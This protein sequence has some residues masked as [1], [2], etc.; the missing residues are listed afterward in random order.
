MAA[1][2]RTGGVSPDIAGALVNGAR[3]SASRAARRSAGRHSG[4]SGCSGCRSRGAVVLVGS[5]GVVVAARRGFPVHTHAQEHLST[6]SIEAITSSSRVVT[7]SVPVVSRAI[8]DAHRV[9]RRRD[10]LGA[11]PP[12]ALRGAGGCRAGQICHARRRPPSRS[13]RSAIDG[14]VSC[15]LGARTRTAGRLVPARPSSCASV[16]LLCRGVAGSGRPGRSAR[17]RRGARVRR[18]RRAP[19]WVLGAVYASGPARA[20]RWSPQTRR[21]AEPRACSGGAWGRRDRGCRQR[22]GQRRGRP[23]DGDRGH[24]D[25]FAVDVAGGGR[26]RVSVSGRNPESTN[27]PSWSVVTVTATGPGRV[28][29]G[30]H[31][32]DVRCGRAVGLGHGARLVHTVAAAGEVDGVDAAP[33]STVV[34]TC[35]AAPS[36]VI[37]YGV[38]GVRPARS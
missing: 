1:A 31:D 30:G 34:T 37:R 25:R 9:G 24:G 3:T 10:G 19:G 32:L 11:H 2:I 28:G 29:R 16:A 18:R 22:D 35:A 8:Q 6:S 15:A 4:S 23:T 20:A 17:H 21:P 13:A 12:A 5:L 26:R 38:P 36:T 7:T 27:A 14:G 33:V